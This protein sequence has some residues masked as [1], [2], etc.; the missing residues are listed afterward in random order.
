MPSVKEVI[1]SI[2]LTL[3]ALPVDSRLPNKYVFNLAQNVTADFLKKESESRRITTASEGWGEIDCIEMI[4]VPLMECGG[5]D[6]NLCEKMMRSKYHLPDTFTG[7][8]GNIIKHVASVNF[9]QIYEPLRGIRLWNDVQKREVKKKNQKYY[10]FINQHLYIP[11]PKG[12]QSAPQQI[13][14]EAYF[15][16]KWE[17]EEY[18]SLGCKD[19]KKC[20]SVLDSEFVC[21]E[22]LLNAV[23]K[24]TVNIILTKFKI[25]TDD[26]ID[27]NQTNKS[28]PPKPTS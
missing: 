21:P 3:N 12:E 18:K 1:S 9:G 13:R 19:C 7:Y 16:N 26:K 22:F 14:M 20:I 24:E 10:V 27:N 28:E 5:V 15:K 6:V 25:Q 2:N 23:V 11:I 4:E 8:N 17:V